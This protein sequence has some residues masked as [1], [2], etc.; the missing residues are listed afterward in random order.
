MLKYGGII[1]T[2]EEQFIDSYNF[3]K[4]EVE[5]KYSDLYEFINFEYQIDKPKN[6]NHGIITVKHKICGETF[7]RVASAWKTNKRCYPCILNRS[8][9]LLHAS[10][11]YYGKKI[12]PNSEFEYDIGFKGDNGGTSKYDLF[13]PKYNGKDTLFEFQSR[14]HDSK[15]EL[16]KRKM[17][18]AINNKYNFLAIDSRDISPVEA[19][20]KYYDIKVSNKEIQENFLF[21]R[22][23]D[24]KEVQKLLDKN[25]SVKEISKITCISE[26]IIYHNMSDGNL[27]CRKDRKEI[28]YGK[29]PVVQLTLSGE[30]IRDFTSGWEVYKELG[31]KVDSC[32]AGLTRHC[33]GFLFIKKEDYE[34]GNYIIPEKVRLFNKS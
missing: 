23:Y 11:C 25:L 1:I 3:Y 6:R 26:N 29:K 8:V 18:F 30:Y 24:M 5:E 31:Y 28:L 4:K 16:D 32:V 27:L 12:Y 17:E 7:S 22:N 21:S 20:Y 19:L 34:S 2:K 14:F 9:S 10:M 13:I 33:H 15:K